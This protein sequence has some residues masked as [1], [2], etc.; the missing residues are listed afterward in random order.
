MSHPLPDWGETLQI[1][2][3][4]PLTGEKKYNLSVCIKALNIFLFLLVGECTLFPYLAMED[5]LRR[6]FL[7]LH[8]PD[9]CYTIRLM[10]SILIIVI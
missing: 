5:V 8:V 3:T 6:G 10:R 2:L 9:Q 1:Q 7:V 4:L